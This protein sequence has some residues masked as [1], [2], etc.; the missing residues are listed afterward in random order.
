MA[1]HRFP[2]KDIKK[3]FE[4]AEKY[5]DGVIKAIIEI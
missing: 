2:L 4:V 1:T 3:A 5:K